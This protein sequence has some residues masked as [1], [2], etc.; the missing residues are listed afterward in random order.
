MSYRDVLTFAVDLE[1]RGVVSDVTIGGSVALILHAEPIHTDDLD[2][3]VHLRRTGTVIDLGPIYR[4]AEAAGAAVDGEYL[5]FGAAKFQFIV[6][7][8][9]LEEEAMAQAETLEV[10]GLR[11][12]V[13]SP[14]Y[15][16]AL[17]L[18]TFRS[19]DQTQ[20]LHLLRTARRSIDMEALEVILGGHGLLARW[21]Q[22][23][24]QW[25]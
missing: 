25:P 18:A 3:F 5:R 9:E 12:R 22:F 7:G 10:W 6:A 2:L 17:K 8:T 4:A 19:K 13:V 23:R 1:S 16:I 24:K 11:T 14:E 20:I 21:H 15:V